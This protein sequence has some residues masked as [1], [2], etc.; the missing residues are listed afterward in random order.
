MCTF[1][2]MI[3]D[4]GWPSSSGCGPC[5][6]ARKALIA[7]SPRPSLCYAFSNPLAVPP[8][9]LAPATVCTLITMMSTLVTSSFST[10]NYDTMYNGLSM[11][12][13]AITGIE[14]LLRPGV[15]SAV[16]S[17]YGI[18]IP[19]K[20]GISS[21]VLTTHSI[22]PQREACTTSGINMEDPVI[23]ALDLQI[24]Q[25]VRLFTADMIKMI[26]LQLI[27]QITEYFGTNNPLQE[28][29][30][31]SLWCSSMVPPSRQPRIIHS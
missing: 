14:D 13:L 7:P 31:K 4:L 28:S 11:T 12:L 21:I 26:L 18:S 8:S 25:A 16:A 2:Q 10:S 23:C 15:H 30:V 20:M 5:K 22:S 6:V 29:P 27:C 24:G 3:R 9:S 17:C 1:E 19:V